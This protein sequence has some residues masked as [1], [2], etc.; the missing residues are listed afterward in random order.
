MDKS[1]YIIDG[2]SF[3]Y[4]A[5]FAL[6]VLTTKSGIEIQAVYGFY[7]M[8]NKIK[9]HK[10]F[11]ILLKEY[12]PEEVMSIMSNLDFFIGMRLHSIMFAH[13][14][15]IPFVAIIYDKKVEAF[16]RDH[17]KLVYGV[18]PTDERIIEKIL[19]MICA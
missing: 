17:N 19:A 7:N 9:N 18:Y 3:A 16:L 4:R 12:E 11:A 2:N 10:N 13:I 14:V 8:L 6:P 15:K 1:F 5:F